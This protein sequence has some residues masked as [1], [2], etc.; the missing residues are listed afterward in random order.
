M[1]RGGATSLLEGSLS[2]PSATSVPDSPG[3]VGKL[4]PGLLA[5]QRS[6][7]GQHLVA[8]ELEELR[9]IRPWSME[10]QVLEAQIEVVADLLDVFIR[11]GGDD[12]SGGGL[13]NGQRISETLHL[14][15][16]LDTA[17]LLGS[18]RQRPP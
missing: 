16:V 4:H 9:L 3:R 17:L 15:R 18:Q 6:E 12:P 10:H 2:A 5:S 1:R 11:I 8:V 14:D 7:P 13:F